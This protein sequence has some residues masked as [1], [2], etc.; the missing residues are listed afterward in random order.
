ML[1][2][3][4]G[5]NLSQI[6]KPAFDM[7]IALW[8]GYDGSF[9]GFTITPGAGLGADI[10]GVVY[11]TIAVQDDPNV[12]CD[13]TPIRGS[14]VTP[15]GN[16]ISAPFGRK[17][18]IYIQDSH[19]SGTNGNCVS[20]HQKV[21]GGAKN[22]NFTRICLTNSTGNPKSLNYNVCGVNPLNTVRRGDQSWANFPSNMH[23]TFAF[24]DRRQT[25]KRDAMNLSAYAGDIVTFQ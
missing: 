12:N 2:G 17:P 4:E 1:K 21:P 15:S 11:A 5:A 20:R 24:A 18:Q 9:Q 14:P 16:A 23:L 22:R 10:G 25:V 7:G 3:V 19:Y 8:F 6:V 13:G